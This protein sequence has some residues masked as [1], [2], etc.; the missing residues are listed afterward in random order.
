MDAIWPKADGLLWSVPDDKADL[1]RLTVAVDRMT[2]AEL[3]I[4][5]SHV[6][7]DR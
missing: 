7:V 1:L 3:G 5:S 4:T 2:A 6:C